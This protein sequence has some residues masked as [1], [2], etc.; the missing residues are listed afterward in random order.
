MLLKNLVKIAT[1]WRKSA[2][3]IVRKETRK[4]TGFNLSQAS[5]RLPAED[6]IEAYLVGFIE[7]DGSLTVTKNGLYIKYELEIESSIKDVKLLYKIKKLLGVGV[8]SFRKGENGTKRVFF[9][10][11]NKDH[12]KKII[13][14][15]FDLYPMLSNK[16]HDYVFFLKNV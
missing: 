10:I 3:V 6:L 14:P 7:G 9:R 8:I 12:L 11:R 1:T 2:G 15:L 13:L 5:Q 4:L 16:Q